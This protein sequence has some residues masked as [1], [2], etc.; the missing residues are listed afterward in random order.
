MNHRERRYAM[1]FGMF[2]IAVVLLAL[3][4]MKA[5]GA[6]V[7]QYDYLEAADYDS[8]R[9]QVMWDS[10]GTYVESSD[11]TVTLPDSV[12]LSLSDLRD[13]VVRYFWY[14]GGDSAGSWDAYLYARGPAATTGFPVLFVSADWDSVWIHLSRKG[15]ADTAYAAYDSVTVAT[16]KDTTVTLSPT[17]DWRIRQRWFTISGDTSTATDYLMYQSLGSPPRPADTNTCRVWG[18]VYKTLDSGSIAGAQ[19]A[20]LTFTLPDQVEDSC[21]D[22][23]LVSMPQ[24]VRANSSGYFAIDLLK[25]KCLSS[26]SGTVK[27]RVTVDLFD[28]Y[29]NRI[30]RFRDGKMITVPDS[31]TYR[32]EL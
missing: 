25:S 21:N 15:A 17:Y 16:P 3:A 27:Y 23:I 14:T 29:G 7:L 6:T 20:L 4:V 32:L 5:D 26:G 9:V 13:Q 2:F 31:A 10:A 24:R 12:L 8:V 18:Y 19:A 28:Y 11:T 22:V 30:T 1:R